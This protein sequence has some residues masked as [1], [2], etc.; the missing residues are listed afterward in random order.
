MMNFI[1]LDKVS[2][3]VN[4]EHILKNF[5]LMVNSKDKLGIKVS[6]KQS[7]C[8][9]DLFNNKT[10]ASSGVVSIKTKSIFV[11]EELDGLYDKMTVHDYLTFFQKLANNHDDLLKMNDY[12]SLSD[13]WNETIK[14]ITIDQKRRLHLF[15]MALFEPEVIIIQSPLNKLTDDG[16]ELYLKAISF[17]ENEKTALIFLS[18]Y[19]EDLLLVSNEIYRYNDQTGLEKTDLITDKTEEE[20]AKVT[21]V[22]KSVFKVACKFEDKTIFFS[23]NEIDFIE[24]INGVS[25]IRIDD[26]YFPTDITLTELEKSLSSFGFF[27]CHRSYLVNLQRVSELIS[28]SKNSYTL[29]LKTTSRDKLPLSRTKVTELREIIGI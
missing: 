29:I 25:N 1:T 19:M 22:P 20:A 26:D 9:I 3:N 15:R 8:L 6:Q 16:I 4:G 10:T 23:P 2:K 28:Y 24:S 5:S 11:N 7:N 17:F 14:K 21:L 18:N 12:F 27:R 13:I